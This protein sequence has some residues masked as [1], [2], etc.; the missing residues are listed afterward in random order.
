MSATAE[1]PLTRLLLL[2]IR[3]EADPD[4]RWLEAAVWAHINGEGPLDRCLGIDYRSAGLLGK[5]PGD[6]AK[7]TLPGGTQELELIS[8]TPFALD[9]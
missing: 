7:I 4:V 3:H 9:H 8:A 6:H 1:N 2:C 5:R